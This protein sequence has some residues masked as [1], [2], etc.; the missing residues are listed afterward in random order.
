MGDMTLSGA[1]LRRELTSLGVRRGTVLLTHCSM[2]AIGRVEGGATTLLDALLAALGEGGTLAAP[3]QSLSKSMTSA[4]TR[5]TLAGLCPSARGRYL[6]SVPDFDPATTPT[7]AMGALAEAIR[8]HAGSRRSGH[9]TTSFTAIGRRAEELTASHPHDR[10]LGDD[11][12][13]GWMYRQGAFVLLLGVG[14]DKCTAFHLGEDVSVSPSRSYRFKVDGGW[15]EVRGARDYDDSD[16]A[17]LGA[18]FEIEHQDE[19]ASGTV[20]SAACR[21]FPLAAAADFAAKWLPKTRRNA[22]PLIE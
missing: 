2:R 15:R 16:F 5:R 8:T 10:L 22:G 17:E 19:V 13:L 4:E 6:E 21:L 18:R 9:P 12:P 14:F 11:S 1:R 3:A 7:E 20:G